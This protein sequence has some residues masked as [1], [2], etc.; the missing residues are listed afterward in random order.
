MSL[1]SL[2]A[3]LPDYAKDLK[4]NLSSLAA[5]T[6]LTRHV[7]EAEHPVAHYLSAARAASWSWR[8]WTVCATSCSPSTAAP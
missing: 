1:E 2:K 5:E 3:L 7:R 6:T 8:V 4:L